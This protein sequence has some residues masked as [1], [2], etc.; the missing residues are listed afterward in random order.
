MDWPHTFTEQLVDHVYRRYL[1]LDWLAAGH[2]HCI[3]VQHLVGDRRAGGYSG[4][5]RENACMRVGA[6]AHVLE[7]MRRIDELAYTVPARARVAHRQDLHR[8]AM[9][10]HCDE[11]M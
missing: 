5:N 9:H 7:H 1:L 2:R 10:H 6:I 11:A 3:V 8:I 4:A